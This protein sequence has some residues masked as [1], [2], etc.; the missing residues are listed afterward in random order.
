MCISS[1]QRYNIKSSIFFEQSTV[2][3]ILHIS[4]L[5]VLLIVC[6]STWYALMDVYESRSL[7]EFWVL[8]IVSESARWFLLPIVCELMRWCILIDVC[9]STSWIVWFIVSES[10]C[11]IELGFL[12]VNQ[13][14]ELSLTRCQLVFRGSITLVFHSVSCGYI[15]RM[16]YTVD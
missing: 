7:F 3:H 14:V 4:F 12:S 9:G 16:K 10:T 15:T 8:F 13:L 11:W 2:S 6:E 5:I 1:L